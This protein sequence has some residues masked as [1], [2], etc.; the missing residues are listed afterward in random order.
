VLSE[1][2]IARFATVAAVCTV[3]QLLVLACLI[4][5]GVGKVLANGLGFALSAQANF[6][7]SARWTWR[8]RSGAGAARWAMFNA[9][10]VAALAANEVAFTLLDRS[11]VP[12][13]AASLGGI[14]CGAVVAFTVNNFVTF[15]GA[16][17]AREQA[18]ATERRPAL[19]DIRARVQQDGVAFFLPAYNEAANLRVI[20][21]RT[22][23]YFRGLDC[24]YTVIVVDD[25]STRDDTF[26][27][28]ER[29]AAAYPGQVRAVHHAQN[30]G[31][32]AALRTG[33][34]AALQTP[35]GLIAFC[36]ADGQFD[37]RSF[38]TLLAALEASDAD[39]SAGY[40]IARADS[41]RRRLM[42]RAWHWLSG[43]ALGLRA[44]RDVD[45]GFKLFT[46]PVLSV[47]EPQING[48]YAAVSPEILA[49]ARSAGYTMTE[50]GVS[51][52]PRVH[53]RQTGSDLKVV[54]LSL[55]GLCQL[56]LTLNRE[57]RHGHA[58]AAADGCAQ[59]AA[60][61]AAD[62]T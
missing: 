12:L 39:L 29:L 1:P 59:P 4:R 41:L 27:T 21:P 15:R 10:A 6:A 19:G 45:C 50:A 5:L 35:H 36:D 20:V 11:G 2:R 14:A 51:H 22:V 33:I 17:T 53:G 23:D 46:R 37:I 56:R 47:V 48:E 32:G 26:E 49:R 13:I 25:G 9:T 42:G 44:G 31:Y 3:L 7:L 30:R 61:I 18:E 24:P 60:E 43:L 8:D 16:R 58:Y 54:L 38:G 28:A 52:Q 40:R 57:E 34:R 62:R 55:I